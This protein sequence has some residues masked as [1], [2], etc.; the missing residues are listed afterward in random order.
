LLAAKEA[1][2][3]K[4]QGESQTDITVSWVQPT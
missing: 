4:V 2:I 3:M 1:E